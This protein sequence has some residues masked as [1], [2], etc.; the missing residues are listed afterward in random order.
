MH[1]RRFRPG[2]LKVIALTLFLLLVVFLSI[3]WRHSYNQRLQ[4]DAA[5][6][7]HLGSVLIE[8]SKHTVEGRYPD[9][10]SAREILDA[11]ATARRVHI[12]SLFGSRDLVYN[13]AQPK[14]DD[15]PGIIILGALV[16]GRLFA[17]QLDGAVRQMR[18][19]ELTRTGLV[20][21]A[22]R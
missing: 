11:P 13:P 4:M 7:G 1:L 14:A 19:N 21:L 10:Q 2:E 12:T 18:E 16:G 8:L 22:A 9:L 17:V 6:S 20:P 3:A 5:I 15:N